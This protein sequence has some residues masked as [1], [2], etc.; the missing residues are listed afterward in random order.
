MV[1]RT[2]AEWSKK[3]KEKYRGIC[4]HPD[5]NREATDACHIIPRH[6][7]SVRRD[8]DNGV[9][10]CRRHHGAFD[11]LAMKKRYKW[12]GAIIGRKKLAALLEKALDFPSGMLVD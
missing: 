3:V 4:V 6:Y 2:D 11:R 8:V 1:T 12:I 10:M 9:P 7:S 5:C